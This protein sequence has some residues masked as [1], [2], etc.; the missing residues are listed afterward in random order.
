[1]D[2]AHDED[3]DRWGPFLDLCAVPNCLEVLNHLCQPDIVNQR[4]NH[5]ERRNF[6]WSVVFAELYSASLSERAV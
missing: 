4:L 6:T 5:S 1:M 2:D 3:E